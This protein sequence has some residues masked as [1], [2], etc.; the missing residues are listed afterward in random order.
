MPTEI[1][2]F[3]ERY[4]D[5][6]N[7]LDGEAVARLY[8]VP[9]GIAQD[10]QYTH[11][12]DFEPIRDNMVALCSLYRER[13]YAAA[14][15]EPGA[16]LQQGEKYAI[17][18]LSWKINWSSGAAPWQFNTT[19]NLVRAEEGWRVLLCTAYSEAQL[20]RESAA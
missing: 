5:A 16:F 15:F 11:W 20:H 2:Q 17:A 1:R 10:G 18:D 4:R 3:F 14:E 12:P 6:F 8:S 7:S 19:Y 13:G 9:S